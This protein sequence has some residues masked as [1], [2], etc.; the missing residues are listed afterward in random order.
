MA[1]SRKLKDGELVFIDSFGITTP[2]TALAKK[3]LVALAKAGFE[4]MNKSKNA[5]LVALTEPTNALR[6]SFRN[7]G[8]VTASD[9]RDLNPLAIL[10]NS[11]V[12]IEKPEVA[13]PI[14]ESRVS[15]K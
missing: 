1:L 5:A 15:R 13:I 4:K 12:V 6:K 14:L 10:A 9:V 7:I 3:T 8:N 2:K 11:Y